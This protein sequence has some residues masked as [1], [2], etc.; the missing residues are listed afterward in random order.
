MKNASTDYILDFISD[1]RE[2]VKFPNSN[3]DAISTKLFS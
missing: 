1:D 3:E 2:W